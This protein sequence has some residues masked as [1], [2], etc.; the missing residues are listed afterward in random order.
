MIAVCRH[1]AWLAL[2]CSF[3]AA[4]QT[5]PEPSDT[6]RSAR[7]WSGLFDPWGVR[8]D[9]YRPPIWGIGLA[10]GAP[11]YPKWAK[12][13]Q[14][15]IQDLLA[16][17]TLER[18]YGSGEQNNA[19][20]GEALYLTA[21][22][23]P[24]EYFKTGMELGYA[25]IGNAK[26]KGTACTLLCQTSMSWSEELDARALNFSLLAGL[27]FNERIAF[28]LRGGR[29]WADVQHRFS[30]AIA[31]HIDGS[32]DIAVLSDTNNGVT[33]W[34]GGAALV[35]RPGTAA[36][37]EVWARYD[38]YRDLLREDLA[39]SGAPSQHLNFFSLALVWRLAPGS[40]GGR[41]K[42]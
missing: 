33:G 40:L 8:P 32:G 29:Y 14:S 12:A 3:A 26:L 28:Y 1:G 41:E 35:L 31:D 23:Q 39:G 37:W 21:L 7:Y 19:N 34:V 15:Q 13:R 30:Y 25:W 10:L 17:K 42:F 5:A 38:S 4:A 36:N 2:L 16:Q 22:W 24:A 18:N 20:L 6:E 11:E 27:A 9:W